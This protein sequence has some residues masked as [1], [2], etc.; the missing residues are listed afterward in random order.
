ML[1]T[2]ASDISRT[3]SLM[4]DRQDRDSF[5]PHGGSTD[6]G[7][8]WFSVETAQASNCSQA[9]QGAERGF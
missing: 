6:R 7:L 1:V 5:C 9:T 4:I 3:A 8:E 2:Q